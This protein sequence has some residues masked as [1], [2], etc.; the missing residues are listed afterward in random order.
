MSHKIRVRTRM[1]FAIP[2]AAVLVFSASQLLA[3]PAAPARAPDCA[4][5]CPNNVEYCRTYPYSY[6]CS[7]CGGCVG[8]F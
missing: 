4:E 2:S 1:L 7:Y 3:S 8:Y 6:S 5:F